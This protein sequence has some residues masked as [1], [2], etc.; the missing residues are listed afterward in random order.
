MMVHPTTS[1][2]AVLLTDAPPR[3]S[4]HHRNPSPTLKQP[5]RR[6][7]A[8]SSRRD[9]GRAAKNF[10]SFVFGSNHGVLVHHAAV[11]NLFLASSASPARHAA[12]SARAEQSIRSSCRSSGPESGAPRERRA[13]QTGS[14]DQVCQVI[15]GLPSTARVGEG[16]SAGSHL[17]RDR[18]RGPIP[19]AQMGF[20]AMIHPPRFLS[21]LSSLL[22]PCIS[23]SMRPCIHASM[24][25]CPPAY[26]QP[27][28]SIVVL[29]RF[30]RRARLHDR[31]QAGS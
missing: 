3:P 1:S 8:D 23:S 6:C 2:A 24:H 20:V 12:S 30:S 27:S 17:A 18:R 13:P 11:E 15:R 25:P 21:S 4:T 7:P 31:H 28:N 5:W 26:P 16:Q 10:F 19:G 14:Q 9:A 22:L 29:A